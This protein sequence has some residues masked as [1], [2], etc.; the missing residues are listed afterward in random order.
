[1]SENINTSELD[2]MREFEPHRDSCNNEELYYDYGTN[3][4]LCGMTPKDYIS[5]TPYTA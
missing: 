3:I 5:T 1:M 4:D 2:V